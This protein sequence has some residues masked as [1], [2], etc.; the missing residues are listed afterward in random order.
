MKWGPTYVWIS[1]HKSLVQLILHPVHLT[2]NDAKQRLAVNQHLHA[3]LFD[4]LVKHSWLLHEFEMV[5][6]SATATVPYTNLD[7]FRGWLVEQ[8]A[9]LLYCSWREVHSSFSGTQFWSG[10]GSSLLRARGGWNGLLG[11]LFRQADA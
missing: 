4:F 11:F 2:A 6:Q 3:I 9:D 10:L 8:L 1:E 7:Q 5:G